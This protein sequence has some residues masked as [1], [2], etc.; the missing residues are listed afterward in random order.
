MT[1]IRHFPHRQIQEAC[2]GLDR[3]LVPEMN[4]GQLSRELERHVSCEV[5][6]ISKIGG[7]IHTSREICQE[8]TRCSA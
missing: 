2:E 1:N 5:V 6:P 8:I 4:L 3:V 7:V